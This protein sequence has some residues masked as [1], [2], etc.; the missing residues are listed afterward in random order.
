MKSWI[1]NLDIYIF[2]VCIYVLRYLKYKLTCFSSLLL[3]KRIARTFFSQLPKIRK[4]PENP[5]RNETNPSLWWVHNAF[6]VLCY[7]VHLP[8]FTVQ[9]IWF[10]SIFFVLFS[11]VCCKYKVVAMF[12]DLS[13][14]WYCVWD[15]LYNSPNEHVIRV[16][17]YVKEQVNIAKNTCITL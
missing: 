6:T 13:R 9:F 1:F 7:R 15:T 17:V 2:Y 14:E 12:F 11:L 8:C 10:Y 3:E 16:G 5:C 4:S